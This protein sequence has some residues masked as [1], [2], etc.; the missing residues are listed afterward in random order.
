[1][2]N[3]VF[4]RSCYDCVTTREKAGASCNEM[5]WVEVFKFLRLR[6]FCLFLRTE[7]F[8]T[9]RMIRARGLFAGKAYL[10][11]N[12]SRGCD[13][14]AVYKVPGTSLSP[15]WIKWALTAQRTEL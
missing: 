7:N 13:L 4:G 10:Q 2:V 14:I 9:E 12:F 3:C 11:W 15:G 5:N 1:M 6:C 8:C